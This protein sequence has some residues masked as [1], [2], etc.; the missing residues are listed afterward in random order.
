MAA[1]TTDATAVP[2]RIIRAFQLGGSTHVSITKV[3]FHPHGRFIA[4]ADT[5][6]NIEL[7]STDSWHVATAVILANG[8]FGNIRG[9]HW[10]RAV[11]SR[12]LVV[13][14]R[15]RV[16]VFSL[17]LNPGDAPITHFDYSV[18]AM[19]EGTE[20][21]LTAVDNLGMELAL[22]AGRSL[23]VYGRPFGGR[24]C[25][26][27]KTTLPPQDSIETAV[28]QDAN[29]ISLAYV[30]RESV[31]VGFT[32]GVLLVS[33]TFPHD[34][35]KVF[36]APG[37]HRPIFSIA[38]PRTRREMV[39]LTLGGG[40][41]RV[42]G[43]NGRRNT[44]LHGIGQNTYTWVDGVRA[45]GEVHYAFSTAT[46]I[47]DSQDTLVLGGPAG[48]IVIDARGT[49]QVLRLAG[50]PGE[51]HTIEAALVNGELVIVAVMGYNENT[52]FNVIAQRRPD[53]EDEAENQEP[54][55]PGDGASE[56]GGHEQTDVDNGQVPHQLL[57]M[58]GLAG[59]IYVLLFVAGAILPADLEHLLQAARAAIPSTPA[60]AL[61]QR[62]PQ[63]GT[64]ASVPNQSSEGGE[65]PLAQG[66]TEAPTD[67]PTEAASDVDIDFGPGPTLQLRVGG[68]TREV[69]TM[70]TR[71]PAGAAGIGRADTVVETATRYRTRPV[72][73]GPPVTGS[74]ILELRPLNFRA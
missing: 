23:I 58:L 11:P 53:I 52:T 5:N 27:S 39:F 66:P 29:V 26:A 30:D 64:P 61:P 28:F 73:D 17:G 42:E 6:G 31:A 67:T 65:E 8:A 15:G 21:R 4:V 62:H 48:E 16:I 44:F 18:R 38:I 10:F 43:A 63:D 46:Y 3:S 19:T 2:W 55:A 40:Y 47:P 41:E 57:A 50:F 36:V 12:L 71:I 54:L 33:T 56:E 59:L 25:Y 49:P 20:V 69:P 24:F 74:R 1:P 34:V 70:P 9:V 35:L 7:L 72:R 60:T 51:V 37:L 14:R 68:E 45:A 32:V 22:I 13:N